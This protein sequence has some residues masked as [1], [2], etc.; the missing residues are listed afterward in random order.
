MISILVVFVWFLVQVSNTVLA[1]YT[2]SDDTH[3]LGF[4]DGQPAIMQ[5]DSQQMLVAARVEP[6]LSDFPGEVSDYF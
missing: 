2:K 4:V 5:I 1:S 3:Q 6:L